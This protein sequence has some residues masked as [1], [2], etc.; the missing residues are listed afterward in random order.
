MESQPV[1]IRLPAEIIEKLDD[2]AGQNNTTRSSIIKEAIISEYKLDSIP[3]L[4]S[5]KKEVC[6]IYKLLEK[7]NL[8]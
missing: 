4:I 8:M 2:L 1:T 3:S 7:A 5:L 6:N